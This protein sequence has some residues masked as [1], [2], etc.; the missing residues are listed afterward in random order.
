MLNLFIL[1]VTPTE[2]GMEAEADAP[3][4]TVEPLTVN[5]PFED[6]DDREVAAYDEMYNLS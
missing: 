5:I 6:M 4:D 3:D 2:G 1:D